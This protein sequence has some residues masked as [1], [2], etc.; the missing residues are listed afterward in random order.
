VEGCDFGCDRT[1]TRV[2]TETPADR[3]EGT[4]DRSEPRGRGFGTPLDDDEEEEKR[5]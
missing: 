3:V 2:V 4:N 1:R 5:I